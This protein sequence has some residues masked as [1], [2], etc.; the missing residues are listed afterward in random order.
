MR[1]EKLILFKG[2][3]LKDPMKKFMYGTLKL[4]MDNLPDCMNL[5]CELLNLTQGCNM[6]RNKRKR[7]MA[8]IYSFISVTY[9]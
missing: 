9:L 8:L 1:C 4:K 3:I 6:V 5:S 2:I 7:F